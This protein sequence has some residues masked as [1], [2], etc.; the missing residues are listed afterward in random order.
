[1]PLVTDRSK[2]KQ[3]SIVAIVRELLARYPRHFALLFLIL[4]VGGAV[5]MVSV[6]AI[7]P[8]ADFLLDPSLKSPSRVTRLSFDLLRLFHIQAGFWPFAAF[9]VVAN[10]VKSLLDIA[11]RYSILRIKYT[12]QRGLISDA[13]TAFFKARWEFF[14]AADQ[15]RLMNTLNRELGNIGETLG[16]LA[17]QLAQ[18]VQLCIYLVVPMW[19]NARMTLAAVG[20]ALLLASPLLLVQKITYR[21]GRR[22]TETGNVMIGVLNEILAAARLIL[23]FGRQE[24]SRVRFMYAFD[25]YF[26]ATLRSQTFET[27]AGAFFQPIGILAAVVALGMALERGTPIA[28]M[29]ALLFSLLRVLP[30]LGGVIS[31]NVS[32]SSFLPSYEQL[33]SLRKEAALVREVEGERPFTELRDG[34]ELRDVDFTYPGRRQ[35][36]QG[37]NLMI[38]KGQMTALVG[39]SGSGKSTI[40]DL[41]LGLQIPRRGEVLLDG[42]PLEQWKQNSFRQRVGYVPQDPLLFHASIRENLLWSY[43]EAADA[44]LWEAC[45]LAN[46]DVFVRQLPQGIDTIVGD[47]GVRL[48]GGQRQRI[49]LARALLRDPELLILDEATSALDSESE[50]LIQ[51]SVEDLVENTTILIIAHR[52][53]TIAKADFVYVLRE[54]RVVEQGGYAELCRIPVGILAGMVRAQQPI[55]DVV[56]PIRPTG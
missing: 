54:G 45:R 19:L 26:H 36:L 21:L 10:V 25:E 2:T 42:I 43:P 15:G 47:R 5:A 28:E 33:V 40:T 1:M 4:V 55:A 30:L 8:L 6:L 37:I 12:V 22:N 16:Q 51:E 41:V 49:A 35:T 29:A 18:V 27:A 11:T 56:L 17:T 32:I 50:R 34:I 46:A 14:S 38:R 13:L 7:V 9:F 20:L 3:S 23:G 53:S 31:T 24:E 48:S 52:L 44:D 39:E